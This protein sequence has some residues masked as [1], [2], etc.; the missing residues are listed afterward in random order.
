MHKGL[1]F[2]VQQQRAKN[3]PDLKA[4]VQQHDVFMKLDGLVTALNSFNQSATTQAKD[5]LNN[6]M[7]YKPFSISSI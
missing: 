3:E 4:V 6:H 7:H 5:Q 1:L 2:Q